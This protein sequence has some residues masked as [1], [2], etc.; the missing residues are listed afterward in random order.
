MSLPTTSA[1]SGAA[2]GLHRLK[3]DV[4]LL[5][6]L[7]V[8]GTSPT[9]AEED[10]CFGFFENL[11]PGESGACADFSFFGYDSADFTN[12]ECARAGSGSTNIDLFQAI[13]SLPGF[14]KPKQPAK[15]S[16]RIE[17]AATSGP[18]AE[19]T[20]VHVVVIGMFP[21]CQATTANVADTNRFAST[22]SGSRVAY[23]VQKVGGAA[24]VPVDID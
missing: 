2:R 17:A 4:F 18:V 7:S 8:L 12:L 9:L 21:L 6:A 15:S 3:R 24:A 11:A 23:Q 10:S 13:P 22:T 1:I 14:F 20:I 16:V 5:G 19:F